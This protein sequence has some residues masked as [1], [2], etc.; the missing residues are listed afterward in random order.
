MF[1]TNKE[2]EILREIYQEGTRVK[3]NY[4][5]DKQAPPRGMLGT[6]KTV[7]DMGTVHVN[8]DNGSS[9]GVVYGEDSISKVE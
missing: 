4:M 7:D 6:V 5:N 1:L 9:L 2:K 3:L 8:W